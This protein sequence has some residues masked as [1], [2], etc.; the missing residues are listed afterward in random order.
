ML[1]S[2]KASATA[3]TRNASNAAMSTGYH[4]VCQSRSNGRYANSNRIDPMTL[5]K[6][7]G[8]RV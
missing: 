1:R 2:A 3:A 5:Q 7:H 8:S 6:N 4:F